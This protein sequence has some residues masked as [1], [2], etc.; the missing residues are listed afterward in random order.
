[1]HE[2]Y[3]N[4]KVYEDSRDFLGIAEAALPDLTYLTQTLTGAGVA[5]NL[6]RSVSGHFD[7]MTLGLTFHVF[8]ESAIKLAEPREHAIDLRIARDGEDPVTRRKVTDTIRHSFIV[9][10]KSVGGGTV[11]PAT[12]ANISGQYAVHYWKTTINGKR[13]MEIDP[14]NMICYFNGRDYLAPTRAAIGM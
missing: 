2:V 12:T 8:S 3:A 13:V 11:A 4:F 10:P 1:M 9:E 5:G 6:E 7:A 14:E